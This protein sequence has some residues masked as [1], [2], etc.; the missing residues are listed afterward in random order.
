MEKTHQ[1]RGLI[2]LIILIVIAIIILSY[3]HVDLRNILES[4]MVKHNFAVALTFVRNAWHDY[5][6]PFAAY[7]WAQIQYL[8]S[9]TRSH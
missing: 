3:Y 8:L 7:L 5:G 6:V 1:N 9:L 2:K 4:D